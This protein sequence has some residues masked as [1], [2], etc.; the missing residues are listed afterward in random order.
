MLT[1][2]SLAGVVTVL[3]LAKGLLIPLTLA[4]LRTSLLAPVCNRLE[5]WKLS[6]IPAVLVTAV[7]AFTLLG[8]G[9]WAAALQIIELAPRVPEYQ[10]N[11]QTKL[12]SVNDYFDTVLS[13]FKKTTQ[14]LGPIKF[15]S[16]PADVTTGD[17]ERP[18]PVRLVV[19]PPSPVQVLRGMF[20]PLFGVMGFTGL[21]IVLVVFFMIWREHLRDRFIR[22]VGHGQVTVTTQALSEASTRVSRYL[23]T[24]LVINV[25]FGVPVAIG[26]YFIGVPNALLW[27]MLAIVLRFIPYIGPWIAAAAPIG[28]SLAISSGW[29][30]PLLTIGLF[31]ILELFSNNV[32]EPWLYGKRT[33]IS[34]VAVLV[35]AVFW[36]WLWGIGGLLLATPLTV[37]LMVIGKHVPELSFLTVLLGD[38]PVLEPRMRV[39]QRLLAGDQEEAAELALD[40]LEH[41]P[42][43]AVYDKVLVPALALAEADRHRGEFDENRYRFIFQ[44]LRDSIEELGERQHAMRAK[45]AA[46]ET[47]AAATQATLAPSINSAK[48]CIICLPAH[49]EADEIAAMMLAQ[50]LELEGCLVQA[51]SFSTLV[52]EMVELVEEHK[53]TLVCISS[54]PPAALM[55]ARYLCRRLRS[56]F[57]DMNLVV[58]LWGA[59]GDLAKAAD[60]IG[61][62]ASAHLVRTLADAQA[63]TCQLVQSLSRAAELQRRASADSGVVLGRAGDTTRHVHGVQRIADFGQLNE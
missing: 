29:A 58:G 39:Y 32:M 16:E 50:L 14:D 1:V 10:Q 43:V 12:H 45:E 49:G 24:Q 47:N 7:L 25:T 42:L 38:E 63:K 36:T 22:L 41:R 21:V 5:R 26:L 2:L 51:V 53:A 31:F 57:P 28:L 13:K 9:T 19:S 34:P 44:S 11:I 62:G 59:K 56:R 4:A 18:Q 54:T 46:E 40:E 33:G 52:G 17:E 55:H 20:G 35:A 37:C 3:Y 23:L 30:T 61:C 15:P 48:P 6:R 27:G 8:A 60:R